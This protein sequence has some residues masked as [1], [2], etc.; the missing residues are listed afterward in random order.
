MIHGVKV[1]SIALSPVAKAATNERKAHHLETTHVGD[2]KYPP[3]V[4]FTFLLILECSLVCW[5]E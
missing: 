5:K 4:S 3:D 1:A 2:V